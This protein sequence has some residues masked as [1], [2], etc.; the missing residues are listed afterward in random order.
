MRM[1]RPLAF[2]LA[3]TAASSTL[4]HDA[5]I[6]P[7]DAAYRVVFGHA[8][9]LEAASAA[10][11]RSVAA[12]DA[13]GRSLAVKAEAGD[14]PRLAVSGSPA[15][16]T[17]H[18]DNGF[19]S[20]TT[21]GSKNLP[22]NEVAGALSASHVVKFGKTIANWGRAVTKAQGQPLEIVPLVADTPHAGDALPVQV[23]WESKPLPG[24][25][26]K[27][28]EYAGADKEVLTAEDGKAV[29]PLVKGRNTI[30][31]MHRVD[32]V[33]DARADVLSTSANLIF[34]LR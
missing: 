9:K 18:Y 14:S 33:G 30:Q 23:L 11:I 25:R 32:L 4:A 34:D 19:W 13:S 26:L 15:L 29:V 17:L 10:K 20:K 16:L 12:V 27:T 24:A 7:V 21:E 6:E 31:V 5:W 3:C 22:K 8:G 28:A 1:F 2:A